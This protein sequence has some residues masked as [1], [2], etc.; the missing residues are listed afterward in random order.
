MP[1]PVVRPAPLLE[2]R[3]GVVE[4]PT[5]KLQPLTSL[6]CADVSVRQKL[7]RPPEQE[8]LAQAGKRR[9]TLENTVL[10]GRHADRTVGPILLSDKQVE[11]LGAYVD[12]DVR[13]LKDQGW[14]NFIDI[15]RGE[16]DI[17]PTVDTLRH[18]ARSHLRHLRRHGARVPMTTK[19]WTQ[20]QLA[21]TLA[22]GPH[23]S[24]HEYVDFLGEELVEFVLKGQWVVLPF[25]VVQ[26][27]PREVRRQLRISP[28]GVVP[29]TRTTA[30]GHCRL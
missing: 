4:L 27:L 17:S 25:H 13:L 15:W 30:T 14:K 16:S 28:M 24:A 19:P 6:S 7:P 8:R 29:Q 3:A 26:Q 18:P 11:T 1:V 5:T 12:R 20:G 9:R 21:S 2:T 10:L 23:K 22:R